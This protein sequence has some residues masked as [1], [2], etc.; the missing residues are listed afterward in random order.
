[1]TRRGLS[2]VEVL[3]AA[4]ILAIAATAVATAFAAG[5][6]ATSEAARIEAAAAFGEALLDEIRLLP[7]D[8][9]NT[10]TVYTLG[11]ESGE[12][13]RKDFDNIDDYHGYSESIGDMT[14]LGGIKLTGSQASAMRRAVKVTYVTMSG[15]VAWDT[16]AFVLVSVTVSDA[17]GTVATIKELFTREY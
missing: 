6:A 15:Q 12:A 5:Y 7:F 2:L 10:P 4:A 8:D 1:M 17:R 9:P 14:S 3:L 16:N 11:P 13:A